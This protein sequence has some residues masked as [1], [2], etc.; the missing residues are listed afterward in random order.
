MRALL[1][2][3]PILLALTPTLG[4]SRD[5]ILGIS[6]GTSGGTDHARVMLKYGGLAKSLS[7]A[8]KSEVKVVF[9]REFA[10][11][12]DGMKTGR[13]DLAMARPSGAG[14]STRKYATGRRWPAACASR[15]T[16]PCAKRPD[17]AAPV[18]PDHLVPLLNSIHD[19][20]R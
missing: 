18:P 1:R 8:L 4:F 9:V 10:Q 16:S 19:T 2:C 11:L 13:L 20:Q 3:L 7:S 12:E 5:L 17:F 14:S 15:S 6:E